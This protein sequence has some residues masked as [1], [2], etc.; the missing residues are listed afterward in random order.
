MTWFIGDWRLRNDPMRLLCRRPLGQRSASAIEGETA[1]TIDCRPSDTGAI[2]P[3]ST[4]LPWQTPL[5]IM[6]TADETEGGFDVSF[7]SLAGPGPL[8]DVGE[9][10]S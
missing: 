5:I 8:D 1:M 6:S 4:R 2:G 9:P 7:D 10:F 3:A